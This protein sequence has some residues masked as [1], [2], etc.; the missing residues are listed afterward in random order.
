VTSSS[1]CSVHRGID[2]GVAHLH[3]RS[4][5]CVSINDTKNHISRL[6]RRVA[7]GEEIVIARRGVPI[8]KLIALPP[9]EQRQVGLDTARLTVPE[10]FNHPSDQ[11]G[12]DHTDL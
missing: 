2:A 1:A 5:K 6:L 8:A 3:Y 4:T 9:S 12:K 7:A 11:D 10:N